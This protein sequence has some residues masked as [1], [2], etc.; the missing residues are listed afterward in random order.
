MTLYAML[1]CPL[2][3]ATLEERDTMPFS[4]LL[5]H[6][7]ADATIIKITTFAILRAAFAS[8]RHVAASDVC[9]MPP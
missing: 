8:S 6:M 1:R 7:A 9:A 5:T 4:S 2:R 3:H